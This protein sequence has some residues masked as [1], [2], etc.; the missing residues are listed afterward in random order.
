MSHHTARG[1][2]VPKNPSTAWHKHT[3]RAGSANKAAEEPANQTCASF[4]QDTTR[5]FSDIH[6]LLRGDSASPGHQACPQPVPHLLRL[7]RPVI[8]PASPPLL[9]PLLYT[10]ASCPTLQRTT[11]TPIPS[12]LLQPQERW[13]HKK[14]A[15][16][17]WTGTEQQAPPFCTSILHPPLTLRPPRAPRRGPTATCS[18]CT[19]T[20]PQILLRPSACTRD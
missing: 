17:P 5:S 20:C 2:N 14:A 13:K 12:R 6:K 9:S 19:H 1:G 10:P 4:R 18:L 11:S 3:D 7:R 8:P 15:R 16:C